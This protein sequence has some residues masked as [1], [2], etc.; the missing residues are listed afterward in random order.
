LQTA[1]GLVLTATRGHGAPEVG[2]TY[3]RARTLCQQVDD[4]RLLSATLA[5]LRRFYLTCGDV[6]V[7][8][9]VG[10]QLLQLAQRQHDTALLLWGHYGVGGPL[11]YLGALTA[12]RAHLEQGIALYEREHHRRLAF[13]YGADLGVICRSWVAMVLWHLGYPE[14]A[15]QHSYEA[16]TLARELSHPFSLFL[17]LSFTDHRAPVSS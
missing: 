8:R 9:D 17:G 6:Q 10:E 7:A 16:L 11:Y 13:Q 15:R 2:Q 4:P 3:A 12:A 1:L 5:G 14:Q